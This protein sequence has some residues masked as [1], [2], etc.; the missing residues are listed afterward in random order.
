M[1]VGDQPDEEDGRWP[2]FFARR[3]KPQ[4]T[5]RIKLPI[6]SQYAVIRDLQARAWRGGATDKADLH[7]HSPAMQQDRRVAPAGRSGYPVGY[8]VRGS[9]RTM[10]SV[11][12]R[13]NE[14]DL[15]YRITRDW[16]PGR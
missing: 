5:S 14:G 10:R 12:A 11:T 1:R 7:A 13:P 3:V 16:R 8:E 15:R 6:V 4:S 2:A 9:G